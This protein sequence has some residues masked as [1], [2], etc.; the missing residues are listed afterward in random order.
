M[1]QG[2]NYSCAKFQKILK[3]FFRPLFEHPKKF[4]LKISFDS[5][6]YFPQ[7]QTLISKDLQISTAVVPS[8]FPLNFLFATEIDMKMKLFGKRQLVRIFYMKING[9]ILT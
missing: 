4:Q 2:P 3:N 8:L 9:K 6:I 7:N 1:S 5:L